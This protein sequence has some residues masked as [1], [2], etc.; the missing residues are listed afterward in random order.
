MSQRYWQVAVEGPFLEPLTYSD[1]GLDEIQKQELMTGTLVEVPLGRRGAV[2]GLVVGSVEQ[3]PTEFEVK[4][5]ISVDTSKPPLSRSYLSWLTWLSQY[6]IY[7]I[8]NLTSS[9][10]PPLDRATKERK[11]SRAPVIKEFEYVEP[12]KLTK[13]QEKVINEILPLNNFQV[14]LVFGVTGSGKT[15]IYMRLLADVIKNGG[16]G[17]VIVPEISLTPQL[18][19]RF[20]QRFGKQVAVLHSQLTD[21]EKTNQWWDVVSGKKKILVGARS[22]LFCPIPKVSLVIVDEEH[23][24]SFKQEDKLKYNARDAAVML[25]HFHKCPVILG[26]ATPSLETWNNVEEGKYRIHRLVSRVEERALPAIEVVDLKKEKTDRQA[27]PVE[28]LPDWLSVQLYKEM[29]TTFES[30]EQVALFLNR[31]GFSQS[32]QCP[33]CGFVK[34]CP[35]CD[36]SLTLHGKRHLVCHYCDYHESYVESCSNCHQGDLLPLGLGTE[37]IESSMQKL[38]PSLR[39]ARA[40]RDEI[41]SR[42]QMEELIEK[43]ENREIDL[44]IGTQMIAKGLDFP[45]LTLVGLVMADIGLNMPDFRAAE[46]GFQLITQV[47]GRSGRHVKVGEKPGRVVI[48]AFNPTHPAILAAQLADFEKFAAE[49][50]S[51]RR[52]LQYPPFGRLISVRIVGAKDDRVQAVAQEMLERGLAIQKRYEAYSEI[53]FLGPAESPLGRLRNQHRYQLLLKGSKASQL[54]HLVRQIIG[55]QKWIRSGVSVLADVDPLNML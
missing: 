11:S 19:N 35:N 33:A 39:I 46:R 14:H 43:M 9:I 23:E 28:F 53:Q 44:L 4:S 55:D 6:Y 13:E 26:S 1:I 7:A 3:A 30:Q 42:E 48:Q 49:E 8:G 18:T 34:E 12:P 36:I 52:E 16:T 38:F 20:S 32:V 2:Q 15:E 45:G 37:Q 10:F 29:L 25:G 54:N 22:A 50:L 24:A 27:H 51:F 21:R 17:L 5:I 40:D 31:R 41:S 47:S